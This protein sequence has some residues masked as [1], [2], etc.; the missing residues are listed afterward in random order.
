MKALLHIFGGLPVK[1]DQALTQ[2]R[3][4]ERHI[5]STDRLRVQGFNATP[6]RVLVMVTSSRAF[7]EV[8][9]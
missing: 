6:R 5:E 4:K 7:V 3:P 1:Q 8:F 9:R 2:S